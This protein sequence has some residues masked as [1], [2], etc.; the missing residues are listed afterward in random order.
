M[1][2]RPTRGIQ[3][4]CTPAPILKFKNSHVRDLWFNRW[5]GARDIHSEAHFERPLGPGTESIFLLSSASIGVFTA[6]LL[7]QSSFSHWFVSCISDW[8][9]IEQDVTPLLQVTAINPE[10]VSKAEKLAL[11]PDGSDGE[12]R[13]CTWV[14]EESCGQGIHEVQEG[15]EK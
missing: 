3:L 8:S 13:K 10:Q 15:K 5:T 1:P 4:G 12:C 9:S 7:G 6:L 11:A 14:N 2:D